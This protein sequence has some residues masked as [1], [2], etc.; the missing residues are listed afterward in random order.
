VAV[1]PIDPVISE[2]GEEMPFCHAL[3]STPLGID[4]PIPKSDVRPDRQQQ[5]EYGP[6]VAGPPADATML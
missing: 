4:M 3:A 2:E 5:L 6:L 1:T